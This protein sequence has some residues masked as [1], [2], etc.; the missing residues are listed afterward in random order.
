MQRAGAG[1]ADFEQTGADRCFDVLAA[2]WPGI[3][4]P[5]TPGRDHRRILATSKTTTIFIKSFNLAALFM[6]ESECLAREN[7]HRKSDC[8]HVIVAISSG[9]RRSRSSTADSAGVLQFGL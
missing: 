2:P 3:S 4:F 8:N 6:L 7:N 9:H 1:I 5:F